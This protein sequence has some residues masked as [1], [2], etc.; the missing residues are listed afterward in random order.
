[1]AVA[2][3]RYN[4][5]AI[6][7]ISDANDL[8]GP[9]Q[10]VVF[11][12]RKSGAS[13]KYYDPNGTGTVSWPV[14]V[15][16]KVLSGGGL[17]NNELEIDNYDERIFI[18]DGCTIVDDTTGQFYRVL[19]RYPYDYPDDVKVLLDRDWEGTPGDVWVVPPGVGGGRNPCI[20]IFSRQMDF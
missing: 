5:Y 6:C 14:P 3:K 8:S 9:V 15:K 7:R 11:V 17:K 2:G 18:N 20:A 19:E 12:C 10:V 13:K 4:W 16:V 1:M